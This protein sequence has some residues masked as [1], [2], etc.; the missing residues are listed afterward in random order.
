MEKKIVS[1]IIT[2][3]VSSL[4]FAIILPE[5]TD[6]RLSDISFTNEKITS[7]FLSEPTEINTPLGKIEATGKITFS[8]S[9]N[10]LELYPSNVGILTTPI[11]KLSYSKLE[12]IN[13]YENGTLENLT[14]EEA[15]DI[16]INN[17]TYTISPGFLFLYDDWKPAS[18]I[19]LNDKMIDFSFGK[20][21]IP[22]GSPILFYPDGDISTFV[23]NEPSEIKTNVGSIIINGGVC[24]WSQDQ[25]MLVEALE[26]KGLET[27]YG[28]VYP[29]KNSQVCFFSDGKVKEVI[30]QDIMICNIDDYQV[31]TKSGKKITFD[32]DGNLASGFIKNSKIKYK[33]WDITFYG[34]NNQFIIYDKNKLYLPYGLVSEINGLNFERKTRRFLL[35]DDCYYS[36]GPEVDDWHGKSSIYVT[37]KINPFNTVLFN[38]T[39]YGTVSHFKK[40]S[41]EINDYECPLIFNEE[42]KVIGYREALVYK[43][44]FDPVRDVWETS[45]G[46]RYYN[47]YTDEYEN[48][49]EDVYFDEK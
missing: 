30:P 18:F 16:T 20:L 24:L 10:V 23:I 35:L 32:N 28:K 6:A 49:N 34:E 46:Y 7:A 4:L 15:A 11:G 36:W 29:E 5:G 43:E 2:L 1:I 26:T 8:E 3:F 39:K 13:F 41:K 31:M 44:V 25:V 21:L 9:G 27:K 47:S 38:K 22:S 12:K 19:L 33:G 48:Y 14:L 17:V 42:N 45:T 37:S 40:D